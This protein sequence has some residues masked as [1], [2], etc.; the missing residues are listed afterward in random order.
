MIKNNFN[1]NA[2]AGFTL[3]E[4]MLA[5]AILLIGIVAL[6]KIF[7]LSLKIDRAAEQSTVAANLAQA[8]VEEVFS[9]NYDSV[10]LGIIEIKHRLS[11]DPTNPFYAYQRETIA[12][13]VDGDLNVTGADN[14]LKK[15]TVTVFWQAPLLGAEKNWQAVILIAKK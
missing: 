5:I 13:Y 9:D 7:P 2:E 4:V 14:G 6:T 8:K 15:I 12:Q 3:L 11:A 10:G 1:K